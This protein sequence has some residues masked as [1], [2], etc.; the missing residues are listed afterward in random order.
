[1]IIE[2][3]RPETL[4]AALSLL[5]RPQPLTLP[6]GGG[7]TLTQLHDLTCAVVD[8][9]R[10]GLNGLNGEG[11][12]I[13][14]GSALTLQDLLE[15]AGADTALGRALDLEAPAQQ[16]NRSTLAG[17]MMTADGRSPLAAV[18]M[19][20]D[21]RLVWLPEGQEV[22]LPEWFAMRETGKK[23]GLLVASLTWSAGMELA[24]EA[25]ARTP[26]DRPIVCA[27]AA[28]WPSGSM[29]AVVGGFGSAPLVVY[30]GLDGLDIVKA[31]RKM[32]AQAGDMWASAEYRQEMAGVMIKRCLTALERKEGQP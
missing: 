2:Y 9:Q 32:Y 7:T 21:A 29:R 27:A 24:F 16:R 19:A 22:G 13:T 12:V 8:V 6:M 11:D 30:D 26:K 25:V 1:M 20:L 4:A 3:H 5:A 10:L 15:Q 17:R 28:R 18:L 23:P 14:A 31:A